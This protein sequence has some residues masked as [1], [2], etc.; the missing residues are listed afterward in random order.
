MTRFITHTNLLDSWL[1]HFV[2]FSRARTSGRA[3]TAGQSPPTAHDYNS[4]KTGILIEKSN[5]GPRRRPRLRCRFK[6]PKKRKPQTEFKPHEPCRCQIATIRPLSPQ[7]HPIG[8]KKSRWI[9]SLCVY[10]I[11]IQSTHKLLPLPAETIPHKGVIDG[12]ILN[13]FYL[14]TVESSQL[15]TYFLNA[16]SSVMFVKVKQW[17][18]FVP[19]RLP[20]PWGQWVVWL[21]NGSS[22]K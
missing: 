19:K 20:N 1:A 14:Y 7:S 3:R 15:M 9:T 18:E 13:E 12:G 5:G 16:L 17:T 6:P 21:K 8:D 2:V 4:L 10:F 11:R 22:L